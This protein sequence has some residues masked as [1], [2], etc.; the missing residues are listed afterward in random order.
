VYSWNGTDA[1]VQLGGDI[2]GEATGD[3]SGYSV[4]MSG[5]GS[6]V[7]I[8]AVLNDGRGADSGHVRVYSWNGTN[9]WVQLGADI[10][11]EAVGDESGWSVSLSGDGSRVAIGA[12]VM[13]RGM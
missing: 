8:G 10:D 6:R 12:P 1:W 13:S 5:D 11:A 4:S 9:A 7:A 2:N 3:F